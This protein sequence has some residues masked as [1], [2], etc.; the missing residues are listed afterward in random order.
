[1][2]IEISQTSG[3]ST[4]VLVSFGVVSGIRAGAR[5]VGR[6]A[7]AIGYIPGRGILRVARVAGRGAM[8]AGRA[9]RSIFRRKPSPE[10]AQ[11]TTG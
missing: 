6:A 1:M 8:A 4:T 2:K 10:L 9:T 5:G 7:R 3:D 11:V